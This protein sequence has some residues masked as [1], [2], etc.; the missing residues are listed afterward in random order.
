LTEALIGLEVRVED[1]N[2]PA[3]FVVMINGIFTTILGGF[4][5][6]FFVEVTLMSRLMARM[7]L[8]EVV[9]GF[10]PHITNTMSAS[11]KRVPWRF[12][13]VALRVAIGDFGLKEITFVHFDFSVVMDIR[14]AVNNE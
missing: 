2:S 5:L 13:C 11:L 9:F 4:G 6:S 12:C 10:V 1:T 7:S 14:R 8:H 3:G